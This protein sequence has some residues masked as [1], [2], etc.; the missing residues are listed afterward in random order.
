MIVL[1]REENNRLRGVKVLDLQQC[2]FCGKVSILNLGWRVLSEWNCVR[3]EEQHVLCWEMCYRVCLR[4][5]GCELKQISR[6][7]QANESVKPNKKYDWA[8]CYLC[9]KELKGA[10]K[11]GVVKNRNNPAFWGVKSRYK[12][13]CLGCVGKRYL[14][15]MSPGKRKTWRKYLGRG[16]V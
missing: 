2:V 6:K 1:T 4:I 7:K 10:S 15:K 5:L 11:K 8:N 16:Y 14:W 13:L 3:H 9:G 12:I